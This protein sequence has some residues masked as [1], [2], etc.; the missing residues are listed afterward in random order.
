MRLYKASQ[1]D[2]L[3]SIGKFGFEKA[4][5]FRTFL[6]WVERKVRQRKTRSNAARLMLTLRMGLNLIMH[7][8]RDAKGDTTARH[9]LALRLFL[10]Q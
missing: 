1:I 7:E 6:S 3:E 4:S 2:A 8:T 9:N 10:N 5:K